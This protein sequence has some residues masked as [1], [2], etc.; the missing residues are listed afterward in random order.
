MAAHEAGTVEKNGAPVV[1]VV[2]IFDLGVEDV[3]VISVC[4]LLE[5]RERGCV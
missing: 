1:G 4:K 2:R 5:H 3:D